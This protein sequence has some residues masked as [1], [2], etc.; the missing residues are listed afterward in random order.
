MKKLIA[1]TVIAALCLSLC[2]CGKNSADT[3]ETSAVTTEESYQGLVSSEASEET[4]AKAL[5]AY[6]AYIAPFSGESD[7]EYEGITNALVVDLDKNKVPEV[8]FTY[9][10][11]H[12]AYFLSY[13]EKSGLSVIS[14][15]LHSSTPADIYFSDDDAT[16]YFTDSGHNQG[17]SWYHE[18]VCLKATAEGFET[19]GTVSGDTWD[20]VS[21]DIW[22]N[23]E[24]FAQTDEKYDKAFEHSMNKLIGSGEYVDFFNVCESENAEKYLEEKLNVNFAAKK[25]EYTEFKKTAASAIGT[26]PLSINVD[27]YDRNGTYEAFAMTGKEI[28]DEVQGNYYDVNVWF[29]SDNGNVTSLGDYDCWSDGE[30]LECRYN[31]YYQICPVAGSSSPS[32]LWKVDGSKCEELSVFSDDGTDYL[33]TAAITAESGLIVAAFNAFDASLENLNNPESG[34]GHTYK[35]Y[36]FYDT[37]DGIREY[38]GI[39]ITE[40]QLRNLGGGSCLDLIKDSG[41]TVKNIY[42]RENGIISVNFYKYDGEYS[43]ECRY[44]NLKMT[45]NGVCALNREMDEG[46]LPGELDEIAGEGL[47]DAACLPELATYPEKA[48]T[49]ATEAKTEN[50]QDIKTAYKN[51]L[52]DIVKNPENYYEGGNT[53]ENSFALADITEDGVPELLVCFEGTYMAAM[54]MT[55]WT[56]ENEK[57]VVLT[58]CGAYDTFYKDGYIKSDDYHNHTKGE[59]VWPF[60]IDKCDFN[61][62][63][64]ET[65]HQIYCRDEGYMDSEDDPFPHAEDA[66]SDGVI[67]Y[68]CDADD[69]YDEGKASTKT[70]YEKIVNK[71]IPEKN[72][73]DIEYSKLTKEN[74]EKVK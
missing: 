11:D 68:I 72:K 47:Y 43:Y 33:R 46:E 52:Y 26:E 48:T 35:P 23:D 58:E 34:V 20:D 31:S 25:D 41:Y 38:G 29:V 36:F 10:G 69:D 2:A 64:I 60:M 62:G 8:I 22:Q 21:E 39:E 42:T 28:S 71:Y 55:V 12:N 53:E 67:Y 30:V 7:E 19:I 3:N 13:G 66:D 70:E 9:Y 14:P 16:L 59:T 44:I 17:T 51:I 56:Y 65:V 27:D 18:G 1:L 54:K 49:P 32:V 45:N 15:V 63:E 4:V 61:S 73:I 6:A 40:S 24:L 37:P 74:I 50:I 57:A 5:E